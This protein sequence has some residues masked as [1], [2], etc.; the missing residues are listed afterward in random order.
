M[1]E[2]I[3]WDKILNENLKKKWFWDQVVDEN[4]IVDLEEITGGCGVDSTGSW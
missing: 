2:I 1:E 3:N 4:V